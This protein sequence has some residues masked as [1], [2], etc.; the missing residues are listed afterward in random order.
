MLKGLIV[1]QLH[2]NVNMFEL[3]IPCTLDMHYGLIPPHV[4]NIENHSIPS[5]PRLRVSFGWT[6]IKYSFTSPPNQVEVKCKAIHGQ[7]T[8]HI[9]I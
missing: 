8:R 9:D 5:K 2:I 1:N 7:K 6:M 3:L 4:N